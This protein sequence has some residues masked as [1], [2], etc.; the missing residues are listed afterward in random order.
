M[1]GY[2]LIIRSKVL[3]RKINKKRSPCGGRVFRGN[4]LPKMSLVTPQINFSSHSLC[5]T[6]CGMNFAQFPIRAYAEHIVAITCDLFGDESWTPSIFIAGKGD[7][8]HL[9]EL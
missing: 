9:R 7:K 8:S 1:P 5:S 3:M 2:K 4:R 6:K